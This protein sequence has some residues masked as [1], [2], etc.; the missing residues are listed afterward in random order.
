LAQAVLAQASS[1][2]QARTV[3]RHRP[4]A[5]SHPG[6]TTTAAMDATQVA[7]SGS[8]ASPV[9]PVATATRSPEGQRRRLEEKQRLAQA[10][11]RRRALKQFLHKHG[12]E[13]VNDSKRVCLLWRSYP[14]HVAVQKNN[15]RVVEM[16]LAEGAD[17][18]LKNSSGL[19]AAEVAQ[20][21]NKKGKQATTVQ[22]LQSAAKGAAGAAAAG[23]A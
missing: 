16:L 11:E 2:L 20:R 8:E 10:A 9:R 21:K 14:L 7:C 6:A 22:I 1:P 3:R 5:H 19:T 15:L 17:P 13:G 4:C 12:F 23:G 18:R